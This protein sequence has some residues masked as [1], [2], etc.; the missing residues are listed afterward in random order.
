MR[1]EDLVKQLVKLIDEIDLNEEG[2]H[3]KYEE[4]LK[5]Y[6]KFNKGVLGV[7]GDAHKHR[8]VDIKTYAKYI[9][10]EGTNEEKREL[11]GCFRSRVC[12]A[13]KLVTITRER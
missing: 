11:M 2:I 4:E 10:C 6:N 13:K 3:A 8:E 9:L 1:E 7:L 12:I 5:K